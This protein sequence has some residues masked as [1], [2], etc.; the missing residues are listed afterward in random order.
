MAG[1]NR[2]LGGMPMIM[3]NRQWSV[4]SD[5]IKHE[6]FEWYISKKVSS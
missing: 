3:H 4:K 2:K 1:I 6:D 5:Y